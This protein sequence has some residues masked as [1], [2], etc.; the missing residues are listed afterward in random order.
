MME[1][2]QQ[3]PTA[4]PQTAVIIP[5]LDRLADT[6][7]CCASL[8]AQTRAPALVLVVDNGSRAHREHELAAACL[9]AQIL[10]LD[11]NRGF[12]GGVNAGIRRARGNPAIRYIWVLN[13]DTICPPDTLQKLE[14]RLA[15]HEQLGMLGCPLQEGPA[16]Q[17][18]HVSAARKLA[19]PGM[20]P[21][22]A[23][24]TSDF[25]YLSGASLFIRRNVLEDVGLFDERFF[26]FFEDAD[27]SRR[28]RQRG[29]QLAVAEDAPIV[30]RGSATIRHLTELQSYYYR[31]GH[32]R[33]V[34]KYARF[35][36]A[37]AL[38]PFIFRLLVEACRFRWAA[39]RG[40]GR[41]WRD[42]WRNG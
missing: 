25:D 11:T 1:T 8:A 41:G 22:P 2:S 28:V 34:R 29:W 24:N 17:P 7:A 27:F 6:A 38:P 33:Y 9:T 3:A 18:R 37:T 30:H 36:L 32:V 15:A 16:E 13:N 4:A 31:L 21:V 12:A 10:R 19:R 39:L 35:P 20:R 23:K 14:D 42:G 40:N 26:F 5:H